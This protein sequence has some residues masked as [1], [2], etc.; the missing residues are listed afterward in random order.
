MYAL[1]YLIAMTL[2]VNEG[3]VALVTLPEEP[4][5]KS[6][7]LRWGDR[8]VPFVQIQNKWET[9]VGVDLD[10]KAG[11]HEAEIDVTFNDGRTDKRPVVFRV[12][13]VK[14]PTTELTVDDQYVELSPANQQRAAREAKE[15]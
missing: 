13:S 5:V 10:T 11:D 15:L 12:V 4:G 9:V 14:F 7:E 1:F 2:A 6:M 8:R 3:S